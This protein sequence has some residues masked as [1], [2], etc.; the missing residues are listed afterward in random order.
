MKQN[1]RIAILND[2]NVYILQEENKSNQLSENRGNDD[3]FT[4]KSRAKNACSLK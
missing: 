4:G 2:I 1:R 3:I